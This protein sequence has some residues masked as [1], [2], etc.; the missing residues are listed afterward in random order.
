MTLTR[1]ALTAALALAP[2]GAR[3]LRSASARAQV[4]PMSVLATFSIVGDVVR[5]VG[6][7][8]IA[9][10]VLVGPDGDAHTFEPSPDDIAKVADATL[11]FENGVGFETWL[12]DIYASSESAATRVAV[13]E[14]L[15]LLDLEAP[16]HEEDEEHAEGEEHE[17]GE[18]HETGAEH[19]E[20]EEH[21]EQD[22]HVW[23]DVRNVI[24]E[25]AVVRD[26]LGA[27]DP[28][29]A[30]T[31]AANAE[32]YLA[33]LADTQAFATAEAGKLPPERRRLV[34]SHDALGYLA[35]AYGFEIVGTALGSLSTETA[36]P[37]AGEIADLVEEIRAAGVPA[38][39]A[40]NIEGTDLMS[41]IADDAGVVLAPRLYTDALG[42]PGGEAATYVDMVRYN[43]TTIV[44]ALGGA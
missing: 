16:G 14:G 12:D 3:P 8:A 22:P 33:Q 11:I 23:H 6:G 38:I 5:N 32:T 21:G 26:A 18:E 7:D 2:L 20:G 1:R 41:Q 44:T 30:E 40:E 25:V 39:F 9:L 10:E 15:T 35:S 43:M 31:Y 13:A 37:S 29:N 36:D 27:A 34:T 42:E 28:A 17:V 19:A 24:A 4:A